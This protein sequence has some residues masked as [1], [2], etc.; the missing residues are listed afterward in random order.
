M[1]H[2]GILDVSL[3]I[4]WVQIDPG[5]RRPAWYTSSML[6]CCTLSVHPRQFLP[7]I[8]M[9]DQSHSDMVFA[10]PV[11]ALLTEELTAIDSPAASL[12]KMGNQLEDLL[13]GSASQ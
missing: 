2:L 13:R 6:S 10:K 1:R 8:K 12:I 9:V 5:L 3:H 4:H 11:Q 7:R